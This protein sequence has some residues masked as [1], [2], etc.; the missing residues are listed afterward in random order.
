MTERRTSRSIRFVATALLLLSS[1]AYPASH[2]RA[3]PEGTK[4]ATQE[5][6]AAVPDPVQTPTQ[7]ME[8]VTTPSGLKY[9]DIEVGKGAQPA[10]GST[11]EVHYSGWLEDGTL[12]DSSVKRG[13]PASFGL[14]A[15][16]K[17]WTEGVG[18]MRAGGKRK[19]I[20]PP[21][22]AYGS[23]GKPPTIP[24]NST[25]IFEVELLSV[26]QPPKMTP[27]DGLTEQKIDIALK[28]WDI[29][30]GSGETPGPQ[31]TITMHYSIWL[32]DG[33]L[34]ESSYARKEPVTAVISRLL[35]GWA[36]GMLTMKVGGKRRLEL[37]PLLAFGRAPRPARGGRPPLPADSTIVVEVELLKVDN[38]K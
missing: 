33:T 38:A 2:A 1:V 35:P 29:V 26:I 32:A 15:V 7:G 5:A 4:P 23:N 28:Y 25:L 3:Q 6:P 14:N 17:G 16:I 37:P 12:F 20:I 34:L 22:L 8:T 18:S 19:L 36:E 24:P 21:E 11:V 31:G 27:I 13:E 9:V 30:A 10:P